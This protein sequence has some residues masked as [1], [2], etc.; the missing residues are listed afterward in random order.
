MKPSCK[1]KKANKTV[2]TRCKNRLDSCTVPASKR[3]IFRISILWKGNV[4]LQR[5]KN[6]DSYSQNPCPSIHKNPEC[7]QRCLEILFF[8]TVAICVVK[9]KSS[10]DQDFIVI[11]SCLLYATHSKLLL[12]CQC[13]LTSTTI[14]SVP[15]FNGSWKQYTE[16]CM[17][18]KYI[19]FCNNMRISSNPISDKHKGCVVSISIFS[20]SNEWRFSLTKMSIQRSGESCIFWQNRNVALKIGFQHFKNYWAENVSIV[21]HVIMVNLPLIGEIIIH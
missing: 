21:D 2:H 3:Y 18:W 12:V 7:V 13:V 10:C 14:E 1:M 11:F 15:L 20:H 4:V 19:I 5:K 9:Q 8:R 16:F 6:T 17:L